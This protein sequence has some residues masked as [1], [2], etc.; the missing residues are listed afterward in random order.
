MSS[1]S[2]PKRRL[3]ISEDDAQSEGYNLETKKSKVDPV[4]TW[5]EGF[6][7][8]ENPYT[9]ASEDLDILNAA[10]QK[11]DILSDEAIASHARSNGMY[12]TSG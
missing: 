3:D 5:R 12:P 9:I 4:S 1:L 10:T 7:E 8:L 2:T 6:P 11:I